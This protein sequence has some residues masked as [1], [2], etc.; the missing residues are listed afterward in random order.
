MYR[1]HPCDFN[2]REAGDRPGAEAGDPR[3]PRQGRLEQPQG[4]PQRPCRGQEV[5]CAGEEGK[6]L[7]KKFP[8]RRQKMSEYRLNN[9]KMNVTL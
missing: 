7:E 2:Y 9:V 8:L 5:R 3:R 1:V 6:S 4:G